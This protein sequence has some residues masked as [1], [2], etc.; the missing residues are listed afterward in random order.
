MFVSLPEFE[1]T[2]LSEE[3]SQTKFWRGLG[4]SGAE[5]WLVATLH[6]RDGASRSVETLLLW[7]DSDLV[8][9]L[10]ADQMRSQLVSVQRMAPTVQEL[11]QN[12]T[13]SN[14]LEIWSGQAER[15][16]GPEVLMYRFED[17]PDRLAFLSDVAADRVRNLRLVKAFSTG[18]PSKHG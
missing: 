2:G 1:V 11:G 7:L 10:H 6:M 17:D 15:G 9:L 4:F 8:P 14:V 13:L 3:P 12:W 5:P 18:R 16:R